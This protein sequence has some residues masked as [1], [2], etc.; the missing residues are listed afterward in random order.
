[1]AF[2]TM[3]DTKVVTRVLVVDDEH[4]IRKA[5]RWMLHTDDFTVMACENAG[6]ALKVL[7]ADRIDVLITD[8]ITWE[9][10]ATFEQLGVEVM[11]PTKGAATS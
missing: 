2:E 8:S 5:W 3:S 4:H 9:D 11:G 10:R 1:M 7:E 6:E